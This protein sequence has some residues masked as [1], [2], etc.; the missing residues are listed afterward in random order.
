MFSKKIIKYNSPFSG[1]G[2]KSKEKIN[3]GEVIVNFRGYLISTEKANDLYENR[4]FDY[5]LQISEDN[6]LYLDEDEKY[7]NHSC[8]PN[9]GFI[10][11]N[12]ELIA[13]RDIDPDEEITFDYSSNEITHFSFQCSCKSPKCRKEVTGYYQLNQEDRSL[14]YP[15]LSPYIKKIISKK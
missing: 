3:K 15:I 5:I 14:I 9:S 2:L 8:E 13:I 7:I 1:N 10:N 4:H 12:G 6:F 11:N